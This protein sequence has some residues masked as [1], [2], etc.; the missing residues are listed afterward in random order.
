MYIFKQSR[1]RNKKNGQE[2]GRAHKYITQYSNRFSVCP[3]GNL[4]FEYSASLMPQRLRQL[5]YQ[6]HVP[7]SR[8]QSPAA[9]VT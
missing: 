8:P 6:V 4:N 3:I 9:T 7:E 2:L 5:L 1:N